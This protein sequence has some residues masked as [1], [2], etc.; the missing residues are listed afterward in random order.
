MF[1]LMER[2]FCWSGSMTSKVIIC[3][4]VLS[5]CGLTQVGIGQQIQFQPGGQVAEVTNVFPRAPREMTQ[6]I[7]RANR[8]IEDER[9]SD[10]AAYLGELLVNNDAEDYFTGKGNEGG[11]Q[12]SLKAEAQRI[13][14]EMPQ[15]GREAYQSLYG[16][17]ARKLLNDA[18]DSGSIE[19]LQKVTSQYFNTD[20]GYEATILIAKYEMGRGRTLSAAMQ[21]RR[22]ASSPGGAQFEPQLSLLLAESW[23]ASGLV[24]NARETL[25][26]LQ[27][28]HPKAVFRIGEED[29]R[30]FAPDEDP[31][32]WLAKR[33]GEPLESFAIE[34]N[35]WATHRGNATRNARSAGGMPVTSLRWRLPTAPNPNDESL[36]F[37]L[38]KRYRESGSPV[39]PAMFPLAIDDYV[40]M[41]SPHRLVVADFRTGKRVW[42]YPWKKENKDSLQQTPNSQIAQ[43]EME[44]Q[45]RI[46]EDA[47][48][49]QMSSDGHRIY[50]LDDMKLLT[51]T[52]VLNGG[53]IQRQSPTKVNKLLALDLEG[54]GKTSWVIGTLSKEE[55]TF[56][57]NDYFFLGAPL[58]LLGK[59]YV[60]AERENEI[61]LAVL[62]AK[63]GTE[64]WVQSIANV[65]NRYFDVRRHL[66]GA[67]P[68]F[69]DGVM[70]CPTTAG[71]IVAVELSSK[72]LLW[73]YSYPQKQA[74]GYQRGIRIVNNSKMPDPD[75]WSDATAT[76]DN[77]RVFV[78]PIESDKLHCLDLFTGKAIWD[79]IPRED[80]RYVACVHDNRLILVGNSDIRALDVAT[81]KLLWKSDLTAAASGRGYYTDHYYIVPTNDRKLTK[82][83]LNTGKRVAQIESEQ[84]LGNLICHNG[85]VI[86]Q[87]A[88]WVS[89]FNQSEP[90]EKETSLRLKNN[91][92]DAWALA[93][94]GELKLTAGDSLAAI[95]DFR[96]AFQ[97]EPSD[98]H[99]ALL[100]NTMVS[101]LK[102]DYEEHGEFVD[103]LQSLLQNSN[104]RIELLRWRI[105]GLQGQGE[106]RQACNTLFKLADMLIE[107]SEQGQFQ[108][109]GTPIAE[110]EVTTSVGRWVQSQLAS[111]Y[112]SLNVGEKSEV[113]RELAVRRRAALSSK[114]T[115]DLNRYLNYFGFEPQAN[116]VRLKL[117]RIHTEAGSLLEAEF[118]LTGLMST[119]SD[120]IQEESATLLAKLTESQS[121]LSSANLSAYS[122]NHGQVEVAEKQPESSAGYGYQRNVD[123]NV[124][125]RQGT[126]PNSLRL[127]FQRHTDELVLFNGIGRRVAEHRLYGERNPLGSFRRSGNHEARQA[128]LFGRLMLV[129]LNKQIVAVDGWRT[130]GDASETVLWRSNTIA[131][132]SN[133]EL[134]VRGMLN[135]MTS[136][137]S[138]W[139]DTEYLLNDRS[140]R[141]SVVMGPV[142]QQGV[143]LL[144]GGE[145]TALN[146][147]T[148]EMIWSRTGI[149]SGSTIFGDDEFVFVVSQSGEAIRIFRMLDGSK[150]DAP[151]L[152]KDETRWT[153]QGRNVLAWKVLEDVQ[154]LRVYDALTGETVWQHDAARNSR[155]W[156]IEND[157]IALLE[158]T[159]EF[160]IYKLDASE[161]VLK[162]FLPL[163][164][165]DRKTL[166]S[167]YVLRNSE[168]YLLATHR[169]TSLKVGDDRIQAAPGGFYTPLVHGH[170]Y[171]FDRKTGESLWQHPVAIDGYGMPLKQPAD[172][173]AL[174]FLRHVMPENKRPYTQAICID[175]RDGSLIYRNRSIKSPTSTF[176]V[177]GD[178]DAQTVSLLLPSLTVT[179]NFSDNAGPPEPTAQLGEA[180]SSYRPE[181]HGISGEL[182]RAFGRGA[183]RALQ[184]P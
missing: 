80:M 137:P 6:N 154:R 91:P 105:V 73:G 25:L 54:E 74:A 41:R 64:D 121:S 149:E 28:R 133:E 182:F 139:G 172:S 60:L 57:N 46:W 152:D 129:Q 93:R 85:S 97:Q 120:E 26:N 14:T 63:T 96:A 51:G 13:L 125:H 151:P 92:K 55:D 178:P 102:S 101:L 114:S 78:T 43:R 159:G 145:L 77:G 138:P 95:E 62:D 146:P 113:A 50:L 124:I 107:Q 130:S 173:P 119:S 87:G 115:G 21:L 72:S 5:V 79:P 174:V 16:A 82:V 31:L 147:L 1:L 70:I 7:V 12:L 108:A 3:G 140:R 134:L 61:K 76:I 53:M 157:E 40:F 99:R 177:S 45:Q 183:E 44:L 116:E 42:E 37:K 17:D 65:E 162:A 117:A 136:K 33:S 156:L 27:T 176:R 4:L 23:Y 143:C 67:S 20:A 48:W 56:E 148:G 153:A 75:H 47:A 68:S 166:N 170:L 179:L 104:E 71:A 171:A 110:S 109:G 19:D 127:S 165:G 66:A 123:V 184:T 49:G 163:E 84:I 2:P 36:V 155:A 8:A 168:Q 141:S 94:R 52:R 30:L 161:P 144:Q 106:H 142:S 158:K 9:Y 111:N 24:K 38:E 181:S 83:D 150:V 90:L 103:E 18:V 175:R 35:H 132:T 169:S 29:V 126:L 131:T 88:K 118:L 32:A 81:G 34:E 22:L 98:S 164:N 69:A 15:R 89:A 122:W 10:A 167:I 160:Y 11:T 86:S 39:L 100:V 59:L 58:P 128:Q 112:A 180:A 135:E